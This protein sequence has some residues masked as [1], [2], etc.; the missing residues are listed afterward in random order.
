MESTFAIRKIVCHQ[1]ADL[2]CYG[3]IWLAKRFG[4]KKFPGVKEAPVEFLPG[5]LTMPDGRNGDQ[6][7]QDG[8]LVLD[9]GGGT[10]DHHQ[11]SADDNRKELR[12]A[13]TL[14]ADSL[15]IREDPAL[16]K[17]LK[18]IALNDLYGQ[19]GPLDL[20]QLIKDR[21]TT[22]KDPFGTLKMVYQWLD[23]LYDA[24]KRFVEATEEIEGTVEISELSI[25]GDR[26]IKVAK[27][28]TDNPHAMKAIRHK[29]EGDIIMVKNSGG[30]IQLFNR[31]I[32]N[33]PTAS[34]RDTVKILKY[35]EQKKTG[36]V[37]VTDGHLLGEEGTVA[38]PGIELWHYMKNPKIGLEMVLNGSFT[39]QKPPTQLTEQEVMRAILIGVDEEYF[40]PECNNNCQSCQFYPYGLKRCSSKRYNQ[41]SN[42]TLVKPIS[43]KRKKA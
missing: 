32:N 21:N 19:N 31:V 35:E 39:V 2:D 41:Q 10:F 13:T 5:G 36:K 16:K 4:Q 11:Y 15:G 34:L 43:N 22:G 23:D 33:R 38:G 18:A 20:A 24:Q 26:K 8:I 37:T 28:R 6:W 12:C 17:L 25:S 30:N 42:R 29:L 1:S 7:L 9:M 14:L 40:A 27:A 3:S